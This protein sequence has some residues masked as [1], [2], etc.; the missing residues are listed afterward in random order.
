M[1]HLRYHVRIQLAVGNLRVLTF[2][3]PLIGGHEGVGEIVAIGNHTQ[4]SPVKIGDRVGVKW[5]AYSCLQCEFVRLVFLHLG[6]FLCSF[7]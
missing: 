6:L 2:P 4:D 5:L 1:A 7:I 3:S